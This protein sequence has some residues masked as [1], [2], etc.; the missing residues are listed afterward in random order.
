MTEASTAPSTFDRFLKPRDDINYN[1]ICLIYLVLL[2]G[3]GA[4]AILEFVVEVESAKGYWMIVSG[5]YLHAYRVEIQPLFSPCR[6]F[7]AFFTAWC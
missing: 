7:L 1:V 3:A 5:K 6:S 2:L 4:L